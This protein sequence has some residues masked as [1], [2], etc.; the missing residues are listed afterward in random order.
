MFYILWVSR[1]TL[2]NIPCFEVF[3]GET[4]GASG[5]SSH[6]D[7]QYVDIAWRNARN[8]ACLSQRFRVDA[9]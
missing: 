6:E 3:Y 4:A 9:F 7:E 1:G 5:L 2:R 8:A